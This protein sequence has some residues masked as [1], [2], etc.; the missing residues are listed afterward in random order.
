MAGDTVTVLEN[1][2]GRALAGATIRIT[3]LFA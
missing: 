1:A 3:Q 2:Q